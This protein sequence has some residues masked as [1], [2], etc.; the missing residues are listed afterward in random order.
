MSEVRVNVNRKDWLAFPLWD[1]I[2]ERA[3]ELFLRSHAEPGRDLENWLEAEREFL[4]SPPSEMT[5]SADAFEIR[6]AAPA[7]KGEELEIFAEES[8]VVIKGEHTEEREAKEGDRVVFSE[9]TNR[10]LFRKFP[11]ETP[12]DVD[13]VTANLANG[14]LRIAAPKRKD[15]SSK[16]AAPEPAAVTPPNP[17]AAKAAS[18]SAAA[19]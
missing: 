5:E 14:E 17:P 1:R 18:A 6:V 19:A 15:A 4:W 3:K 2:R 11:F 16:A 13:H 7:F 8:N 9:F 12:V 10:T